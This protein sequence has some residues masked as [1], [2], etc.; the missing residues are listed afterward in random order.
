MEMSELSVVGFVFLFFL[1]TFVIMPKNLEY[2]SGEIKNITINGNT[3]YEVVTYSYDK[4]D[5]NTTHYF[6]Y[7]LSIISIIGMIFVIVNIRG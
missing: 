7:F 4:Y 1:S 2:K 3:T 6:S 5:D